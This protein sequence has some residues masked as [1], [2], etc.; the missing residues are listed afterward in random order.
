MK[1]KD[2][3]YCSVELPEVQPLLHV[4][5]TV[6]ARCFVFYCMEVDRFIG[7][8]VSDVSSSVLRIHRTQLR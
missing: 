8:I 5:D 6:E 4:D 7:R 2:E 3:T 1:C